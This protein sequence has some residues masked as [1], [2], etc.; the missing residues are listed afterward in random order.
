MSQVGYYRYK[1]SDAVE[2]DQ[3]VQFFI[4][5]ALVKTC[6]V[7]ALKFCDGYRLLKYLD[8]EGKYR[9]YPF[10]KNWQQTD[11]PTLIGRVNNFVT[12]II[13]SQSDKRNIGYNNE[14]KLSLTATHVSLEEL[15]KLS[16]KSVVGILSI[17]QLNI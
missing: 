10:N 1:L 16:D 13:D 11:K 12:S 5:G 14:R 2:G 7:K 9:F 8:S 17:R 6:T 3:Q 15:E 4:N